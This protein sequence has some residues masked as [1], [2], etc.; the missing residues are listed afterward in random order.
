MAG[1]KKKQMD[2]VELIEELEYFERPKGGRRFTPKL[3]IGFLLLVI[4][5]AGV[6]FSPLFAVKEIKEE[7]AEHYTATELAEMISLSHGENLILFGKGRAR[8]ILEQDPYIETAKL[9]IALPHTMV[10]QVKERKVRGYVPYMGAYLY[11]DKEGRV[12]ETQNAYHEALP[13]VTGLKFDSFLLGEVLPVE[14]KDALQVVL[15]M[16]QMMKKYNLLDIVVEID[17]TDPQDVY[18]YVNKVEIRL[19]DMK[20]ADQKV[21]ILGEIMKTIPQEDRGTL[22]LR[23]LKKPIIFQYLT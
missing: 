1:K 23:D 2:R 3:I 7:G 13:I 6:L 15:Q 10:I 19:G 14:N 20:D 9:K 4:M 12:L 21:C 22:D 17:V 5:V 18:A 16:S 8:E 11:I